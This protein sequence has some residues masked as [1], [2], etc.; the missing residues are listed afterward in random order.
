M[1]LCTVKFENL[2]YSLC[3]NLSYIGHINGGERI[4]R[5]F[6]MWSK[7][8]DLKYGH[9]GSLLG[10]FLQVVPRFL[11]EQFQICSCAQTGINWILYH[12]WQVINLKNKKIKKVSGETFSS[13]KCPNMAAI[14]IAEL[15]FQMQSFF[16]NF[17]KNTQA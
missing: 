13:K 5:Y 15:H 10:E 16:E 11:R 14:S 17:L 6:I 4:K 8:H 9:R 3:V 7:V 1:I 12:P 2:C